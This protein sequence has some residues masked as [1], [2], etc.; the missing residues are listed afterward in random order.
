MVAYLDSQYTGYHQNGQT[1]EIVLAAYAPISWRRNPA[2]PYESVYLG[3]EKVVTQERRNI[4]V[5]I[6]TEEGFQRTEEFNEPEDHVAIELEFMARLC[7]KMVNMLVAGDIEGA[8]KRLEVQKKFIENHIGVWIPTFC[9]DILKS[10]ELD[11]YKAIAKIT[12]GFL[13]IDHKNINSSILSLRKKRKIS[14]PGVN[15]KSLDSL[16]TSE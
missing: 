5:K 6:Y 15:E 11:Y 10:A 8:I 9:N 13:T 12:R 16:C 1:P 7:W 4:I 2:H 14:N 3:K